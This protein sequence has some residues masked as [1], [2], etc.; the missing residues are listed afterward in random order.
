MDELINFWRNLD[1]NNRPFIRNY[2][3]DALAGVNQVNL[4]FDQF[5]ANPDNLFGDNF[6]IHTGLLPV[7]Y[8]GNFQNARILL[9]MT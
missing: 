4:D 7:P 9:L 3:L 5:V 2:D 6:K 8:T 1:L